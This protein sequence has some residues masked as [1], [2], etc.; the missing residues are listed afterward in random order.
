MLGRSNPMS[1]NGRLKR[2]VRE[3]L[4]NSS[5]DRASG[6]IRAG[7]PEAV[8]DPYALYE[9][10]R[11]AG[12]IYRYKG[13]VPIAASHAAVRQLSMDDD[14]FLTHRGIDRFELD[15][16]DEADRKRVAEL[17]AFEQLQ[18]SGMN[19]EQIGRAHV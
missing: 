8:R 16:L 2:S 3:R 9:A 6:R 19:G 15:E 10:V 14:R 7:E 12:D 11:E 1:R 18:M 5:L 4:T 17:C 13:T